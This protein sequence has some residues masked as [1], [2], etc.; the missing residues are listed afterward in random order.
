MQTVMLLT[1]RLENLDL[2]TWRLIN[3]LL[4]TAAVLLLFTWRGVFP[5]ILL[6]AT[7]CK[8][9]GTQASAGESCVRSHATLRTGPAL[10]RVHGALIC[11]RENVV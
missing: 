6:Q 2:L 3:S 7:S 4:G 11:I 8:A 10:W 9:Q 1:W 5:T